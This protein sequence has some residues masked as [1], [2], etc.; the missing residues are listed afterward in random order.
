MSNRDNGRV[1]MDSY[2]V[3]VTNLRGH[4]PSGIFSDF[5]LAWKAADDKVR[6][7]CS[8]A[9]VYRFEIDTEFEGELVAWL[10]PDCSEIPPEKLRS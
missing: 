9:A 5:N 6:A 3:M 4:R 1:A 7:G 8:V 10:T 2:L